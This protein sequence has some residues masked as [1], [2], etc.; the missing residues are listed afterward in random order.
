MSVLTACPT[1]DVR[2]SAKSRRR[3]RCIA[4]H[5]LGFARRV[6]DRV[7]FLHAGRVWES[8]PPSILDEPS[9]AELAGYLGRG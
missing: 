3:T 9:T 8:G 6:A 7:A 2:P 5:E 1:E 4:T